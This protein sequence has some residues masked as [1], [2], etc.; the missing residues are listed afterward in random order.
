MVNKKEITVPDFYKTYINALQEDNL[1]EALANNTRRFR[2]LLKQ[3]PHKKINYAYAEGKWT[4]K[5]L[6]Q[7]IIDAERVFIYRALTFARMDPAPLPGFD[8]NNWAITA[9]APKRKWNDLV[10]EFK[11]LRSANE[12]FLNSLDDDQLLQTGSANNNTISVA[13]LAFV[14]AGH[15]A[16]H[17]RI[18]RERYLNDQPANAKEEPVKPAVKG[19]KVKAREKVKI[20]KKKKK[21]RTVR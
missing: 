9:K 20:E 14:C 5:E 6:L 15:V 8:E 19:K 7:H 21:K 3:I 13:G 17:M 12:L 16:H 10:D 4:I 18:I 1:P 11:A 2:K